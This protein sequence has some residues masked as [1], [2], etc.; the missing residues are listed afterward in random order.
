MSVPDKSIDPRLLCAAKNVFLKKGF[1]MASLAEI[2]QEAGV[3]T[4]ALYK[5]YSGKEEL[6][7]EVVSGTIRE[8]EE[9]V[10]AIKEIDLS[11]LTDQ[12]IYDGFFMETEDNIKW[13]RFLYERKKEVILLIKC[14]SGTRY[15]NFQYDWSGVTANLIYRYYLEARKRE[16]T[17]KEISPT[18]IH[19]LSAAV[20]T[21]YYEP[22][23]QDYCWEQIEHHAETIHNFIDWHS[24]LAL[25]KPGHDS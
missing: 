6:F 17:T 9:K 4:G 14:A 21:L 8:L 7:A 3:T 25:R 22:F 13:L 19:I 12:E 23:I 15:S 2:C 24:V 16:L 10:S 1:E 11:Q 5:R 20:W 18:E